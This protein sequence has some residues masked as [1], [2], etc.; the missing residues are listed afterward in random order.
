MVG[1]KCVFIVFLFLAQSLLELGKF[2][3]QREGGREVERERKRRVKVQVNLKHPL[4]EYL[5][6]FFIYESQFVPLT[7]SPLLIFL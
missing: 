1:L 2:R 5:E 4:F 7:E 6:L 3:R